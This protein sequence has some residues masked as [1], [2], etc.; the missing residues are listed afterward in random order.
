M[1]GTLC[2]S[3]ARCAYATAIA[4]LHSPHELLQT[5]LTS[6]PCEHSPPLPL[7]TVVSAASRSNW[8][9]M[10]GP[11]FSFLGSKPVVALSQ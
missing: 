6:K 8:G 3:L 11:L 2:A 1:H 4:P 9:V 7:Q 5:C 10:P